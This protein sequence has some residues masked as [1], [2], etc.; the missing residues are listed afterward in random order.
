MTSILCKKCGRRMSAG[1]TMCPS[2]GA[3]QSHSGTSR[4]VIIGVAM[5][6]VLVVVIAAVTHQAFGAAGVGI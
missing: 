4:N 6:V 5:L 2:C 3:V 1:A